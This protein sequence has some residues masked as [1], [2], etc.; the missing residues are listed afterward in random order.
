MNYKQV[1][2]IM[3]LIGGIIL[4]SVG[5]YINKQVEEGNSQIFD[6]QRKVDQGK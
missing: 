2:G 5:V 3:I 6:A 4:F 1:L